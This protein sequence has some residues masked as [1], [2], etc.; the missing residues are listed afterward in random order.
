MNVDTARQELIHPPRVDWKA[1]G[2]EAVAL[3]V[4]LVIVI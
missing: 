2:W 3:T 1:L 4:V